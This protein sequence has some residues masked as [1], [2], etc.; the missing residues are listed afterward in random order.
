MATALPDSA[1]AAAN[2][3]SKINVYSQLTD[4]TLVEHFFRNGKWKTATKNP[5]DPGKAKLFTPLAASI[6]AV[7]DD[8]DSTNVSSLV[9]P[10][11][12]PRS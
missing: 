1:I 9:V 2:D 12:P 4:G 6:E 8:G 7:D 3:G 5:A 10:T 11:S